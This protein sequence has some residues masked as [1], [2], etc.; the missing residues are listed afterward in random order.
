L[1]YKRENQI[2]KAHAIL[3]NNSAEFT[4]YILE[5]SRPV[6]SFWKYVYDINDLHR[7]EK[8]EI[9]P[10]EKEISRAYISNNRN[11]KNLFQYGM[12]RYY[13][14]RK[15]ADQYTKI[16]QQLGSP[17]D[18]VWRVIGPFPYGEKSGFNNEYPPEKK[19]DINV[20]YSF[21][22][23]EIQWECGADGYTDGYLDFAKIYPDNAWSVAY[24]LVYVYSPDER[25]AQ[26]RMG[27]DEACKLW[28]NNKQI[29]QHYIK[30][31]AVLDRDLVT[32]LLHPGYN[33]VLIKVTNN[34]GDWGFFFRLTD[35]DGK[36][37]PDITFHSYEE[38]EKSF[39]RK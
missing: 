8:N 17:Q 12:A 10:F 37:F 22:D 26:I 4:G 14:S 13:A 38:V 33:K 3:E 9:H 6:W 11:M 27:A 34:F 29:W 16:Y 18:T 35:E 2:Q 19:V 32:V 28:L 30:Q 31:D 25:I 7:P 21:G 36:G 5:N 39:A 15:N 20:S 24:A 1:L 23:R